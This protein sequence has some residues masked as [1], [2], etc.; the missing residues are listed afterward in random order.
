MT[1][2]RATNDGDPNWNYGIDDAQASG[3]ETEGAKWWEDLLKGGVRNNYNTGKVDIVKAAPSSDITVSSECRTSSFSV[4]A[5]GFS[6]GAGG[7]ICP[8][9][10][11][12]TRTSLSAVPEYHETQ[13]EGE[14]HNDR[15]A[16]ALTA[17]RDKPGFPLPT[18]SSSTT[19]SGERDNRHAEDEGLLPRCRCG[20]ARSSCCAPC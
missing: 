15:E 13:W 16:H 3:H 14:S 18:A 12:V 11:N 17:Y 2:Y 8:D 9:R 19:R 5:G 6:V 10:W 20:R 4:G 7:T 1:R